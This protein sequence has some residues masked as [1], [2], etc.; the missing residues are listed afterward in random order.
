MFGRLEEDTK[1]TSKLGDH[2]ALDAI[3]NKG[4]VRGHQ[5]EV[6][7]ED[8][9]LLL[10]VHHLVH[11]FERHTKRGLERKLIYLGVIFIESGLIESVT[12][13]LQIKLLTRVILNMR[14]F[15]KDFRESLL[16]QPLV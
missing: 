14:K 11:Q 4:A 6:R 15:I 5:G 3:H 8:L 12:E 16:D 1:A 9:L 2:D 10:L 7:E 13:E